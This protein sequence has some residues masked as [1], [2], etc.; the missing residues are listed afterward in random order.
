MKSIILMITLF[1]ALQSSNAQSVIDLEKFSAKDDVNALLK[2]KSPSTESRQI[3]TTLPAI[4]T[5]AVQHFAFGTVKLTAGGE[6][7][8]ADAEASKI[9][10]LY[11]NAQQKE[12]V[13][14]AI[15]LEKTAESKLLGN[16]IAQHYGK[17]TMLT[18]MPAANSKGVIAGYP[19]R[20]YHDAKRKQT[21][22]VADSYNVKNKKPSLATWVFIIND[23][24][25][26]INAGIEGSVVKVLTEMYTQ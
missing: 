5:R 23:G 4:T 20:S 22:I 16:Y 3:P 21:V 19:A 15:M 1:C 24:V 26:A 2:D 13:G 9:S 6:A 17:A 14:L 8:P 18:K 7:G 10:F 25:E 12:V 11:R